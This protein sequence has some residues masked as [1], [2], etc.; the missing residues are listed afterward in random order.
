MIRSMLIQ[1]QANNFCNSIYTDDSHITNG[2][3]ETKVVC[4]I[5]ELQNFRLKD[6]PDFTGIKDP[7][8]SIVEFLIEAMDRAHPASTVILNTSNELENDVFNVL[9]TICSLVFMLE[10]CSS[11][12]T[13]HSR[14]TAIPKMPLRYLT[15]ASAKY[16]A[17]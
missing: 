7:N 16:C 8:Y 17:S 14:P 11:P 13:F 12:C 10:L 9:S 5:L 3:L 2:Y 1:F 6:L 15:G 4:C